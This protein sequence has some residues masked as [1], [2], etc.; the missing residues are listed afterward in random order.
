MLVFVTIIFNYCK[1]CG[2]NLFSPL[3]AV[4]QLELC[5]SVYVKE[6]CMQSVRIDLRQVIL[7]C[8]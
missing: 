5:L 3:S 7:P 1:H 4:S 8:F 6:K 2:R